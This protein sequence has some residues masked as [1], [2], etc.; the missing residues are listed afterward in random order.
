MSYRLRAVKRITLL[1][2]FGTIANEAAAWDQTRA[3]PPCSYSNHLKTSRNFELFTAAREDGFGSLQNETR[4]IFSC[5]ETQRGTEQVIS[6]SEAR[7]AMDRAESASAKENWSEELLWLRVAERALPRLSDRF[8]LKRADALM[9]MGEPLEA[10]KA[11]RTALE[12]PKRDYVALARIGEVRCLLAAGNKKG[13][14]AYS[15]LMQLYPRLP[16]APELILERARAR[17]RWGDVRGAVSL[18]QHLD[19][20]FPGSAAAVQAR[21]EIEK[22][23]RNGYPLWNY[24]IKE[25]AARAELLVK[26]GSN[27]LALEAIASLLAVKDLD[28]DLRARLQRI[29]FR[30]TALSQTQTRSS[31]DSGA[32]ATTGLV[33]TSANMQSA[34]EAEQT[35]RLALYR[36]RRIQGGRPIHKLEF[37]KLSTVLEIAVS[38]GLVDVADETLNAMQMRPKASPK[39]RFKEAMIAAGVASDEAIAGLLQTLVSSLG[40]RVAASYHYAR[41]LERLGRLSEAELF[42]QKVLDT[43]GDRTSYYAMWAEQRLNEIASG[44]NLSCATKPGQDE[45]SDQSADEVAVVNVHD[46]SDSALLAA[47]LRMM[48]APSLARASSQLPNRAEILSPRNVIQS[49]QL[50]QKL[51]DQLAPLAQ[52]HAEAYPWFGRASDLIAVGEYIEAAD[53]LYEGYSAWRDVTG[54]PRLRAGYEALFTGGAPSR[55]SALV[56]IVRARLALTRVD[57]QVLAEVAAS[58]GDMGLAFRLGGWY[59]L[60]WPRPY[61]LRARKA[62]RKFGIDPNLLYAV[63]RVESIYDHRIV[64]MAGAIGLMQIMPGT[65][66]MIADDM[67]VIG[68]RPEDLFNPET[69]LEFSAQHLA[70][71][72]QRFQGRTAL[73]IAAYNAGS[74]NVQRWMNRFGLNVPLDVFLERIPFKETYNYVRRVLSH[75]SVY[76]AQQGLPM[77]RLDT[78]LPVN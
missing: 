25:R 29:A 1:L 20:L 23:R 7:V 60:G 46:A 71:L 10:C 75:Y 51:R 56:K 33:I 43:E 65:G 26:S 50:V 36:I 55:R 66:Q 32:I 35:R 24:S 58:L 40:V 28:K 54:K 78:R 64:S 48:G 16:T 12:S 47:V 57:R 38:N 52:R 2:F 15:K 19:Y 42:Y 74:H 27:N 31:S 41:A 30:I 8:A 22:A 73:A 37:G 59:E 11:Y 77:E 18:Y 6:F 67:E 70:F 17:E 39:A 21:V 76:R 69:A 45:K 9:Q 53:E 61:A 3:D 49:E 34:S 72:I 13:E 4:S 62:A 14:I 63:M 44:R 68:F 5:G